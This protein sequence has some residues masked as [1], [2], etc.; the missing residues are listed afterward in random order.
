M[1]KD[2]LERTSEKHPSPPFS[3]PRRVEPL[4]HLAIPLR[5]Q[6]SWRTAARK[7]SRS[8]WIA[9]GANMELRWISSEKPRV[10]RPLAGERANPECPCVERSLRSMEVFFPAML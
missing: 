8:G 7:M 1:K 9:G 5:P 10:L 6:S 4:P 3:V 2:P